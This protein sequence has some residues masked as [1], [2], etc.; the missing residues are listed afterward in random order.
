MFSHD[1]RW[2]FVLPQS[3]RP[4]LAA[5]HRWSIPDRAGIRPTITA[6]KAV[7]MEATHIPNRGVAPTVPLLCRFPVPSTEVNP[8]YESGSSGST[9]SPKASKK[10]GRGSAPGAGA[11]A[12][13]CPG[14][15]FNHRARC[16]SPASVHRSLRPVN[17][18]DVR[19][20]S[21]SAAVS[22]KRTAPFERPV[23]RLSITS[24]FQPT[25]CRPCFKASALN[26]I[27]ASP[28]PLY[29]RAGITATS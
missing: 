5:C 27:L 15:S 26:E 3:E 2:R 8:G 14:S 1:F 29:P 25:I 4:E 24:N 16:S 11:N 17:R 6:L 10:I 12:A 18:S 28:A 19:R 22:G 7:E 23:G 20:F 21:S 9:R 13:I